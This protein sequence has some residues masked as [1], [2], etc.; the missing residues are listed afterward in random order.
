[1]DLRV[2]D[3]ESLLQDYNAQI[4]WLHSLIT[5]KTGAHYLQENDK[6]TRLRDFQESLA[7]TTSLLT[8]AGK[9]QENFNSIHVAGTSGK[10]SVVSLISSILMGCGFRTGHHVSPFLQVS[11]EKIILDG[12]RIALE[13]FNQLV[14]EFRVLYE[15]WQNAGEMPRSLK[16][17][18]AWMALTFLSFSKSKVDWA[19][20]ETGM[21]GRYDPSN[22]LPAKLAVI[23]NV[24][25]DHINELGPTLR[26]IA[27]HKAGIIKENQV[28]ITASQHADVLDVLENEARLQHAPL[29]R[30][31]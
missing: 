26:D 1:M 6:E 10:G 15:T 20:I 21:G 23:T 11:T 3:Q 22:A 19:V 9:P 29:Y 16:Y 25:Y 13:Q 30:L 27:S 7:R 24:D 8:Y 17:T 2:K 18:E 28:A 12:K 5:D 4:Q 14:R 31:T